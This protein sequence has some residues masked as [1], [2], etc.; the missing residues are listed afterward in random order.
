MFWKNRN[1]VT[2]GLKFYDYLVNDINCNYAWRCHKSNIFE[3]YKN[4]IKKNH[5]EIGPGTGYFLK[6]NYQINKL[7]I[8]DI[9]DDTLSFTKKN[10]D[11]VY[12]I[13]SINHNIFSDKLKI[14]DLNSVGLNYVLHCVPG[15]LE[16]NVDNLINNL[17]SNNKINFFGATVVS[18]KNLQN[19]LSSV[20]LF[21]LNK[22]NIF[23]N[24]LDTSENLINY[25]KYNQ[26][27]FHKKIVGNV[28]IFSFEI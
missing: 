1:I 24:E 2:K 8:M 28:L 23:N 20:E 12:N 27:K 6:N 7:Y 9:N 16:D 10:L 19:T 11:S 22:Y 4:N 14:K 3:N 18:D 5:L 15:R 25:L 13:E 21:F 17:E 26:I